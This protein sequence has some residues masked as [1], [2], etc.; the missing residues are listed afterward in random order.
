[1]ALRRRQYEIETMLDSLQS[2][3]SSNST[4]DISKLSLD[5]KQLK[6][7][8]REKLEAH[9]QAFHPVWGQLFKAGFQESR[10]AHQIADYA[11]VYTSRASNLGL[12][13]PRRVYRPV[14]DKMPHDHFIEGL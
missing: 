11:C 9:N 3:S 5:L 13:S 4:I 14:R 6:S 2:S 8:V 1:M 10:F 12:S 7:F